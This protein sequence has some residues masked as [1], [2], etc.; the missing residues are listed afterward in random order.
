MLRTTWAVGMP[1]YTP[2]HVEIQTFYISEQLN[3]F[4]SLFGDIHMS[5][6]FALRLKKLSHWT[7]ISMCNGTESNACTVKTQQSTPSTAPPSLC[8]DESP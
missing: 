4:F 5:L 8:T 1:L 2:N 7:K 3:T 6:I